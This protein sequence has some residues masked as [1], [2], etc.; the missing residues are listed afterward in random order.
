MFRACIYGVERE[1]LKIH[2]GKLKENWY[3]IRDEYAKVFDSV[4][5]NKLWKIIKR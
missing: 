2:Q 4:D 1:R 3:L 5:H